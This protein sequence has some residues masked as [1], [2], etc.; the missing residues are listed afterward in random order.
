M[1]SAREDMLS[2]GEFRT[3]QNWIGPSRCSLNDT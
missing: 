2:P 1:K 3:T